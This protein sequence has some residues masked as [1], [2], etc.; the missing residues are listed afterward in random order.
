MPLEA[1]FNI[2]TLFLF[3]RGFLWRINFKF[4]TWYFSDKSQHIRNEQCV[5]FI[6][7]LAPLG[8]PLR[9][10]LRD[11]EIEFEIV[12][13][14]F[15]RKLWLALVLSVFGLPTGFTF[16]IRIDVLSLLTGMIIGIGIGSRIDKKA[17][18]AGR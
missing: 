11:V 16:G 4:F 9:L 8:L 6:D 13:M 7:F 2:A 14:H 10:F 17:Y 18:E 1:W 5:L 3:K 15:Y 12:P